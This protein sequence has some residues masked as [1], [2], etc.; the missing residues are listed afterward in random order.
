LRQIEEK[1][2]ADPYRSTGKTII[3]LGISFDTRGRKVGDWK[4]KVL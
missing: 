3:G 2:Y 1:G 4:M